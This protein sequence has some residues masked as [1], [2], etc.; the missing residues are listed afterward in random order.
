MHNINKYFLVLVCCS[1]VFSACKQ[2]DKG[3]DNTKLEQSKIED[4]NDPNSTRK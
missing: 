1:L 3:Q 4:N 2:E